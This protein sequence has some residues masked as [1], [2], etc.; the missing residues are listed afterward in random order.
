MAGL[1]L[2]IR[3]RGEAA[4]IAA[5]AGEPRRFTLKLLEEAKRYGDLPGYRIEVEGL[6]TAR[7]A[8]GA[9]PGPV[10]ALTRGA[11]VE[12]ALV[13]QMKEPT[14]I[15]WHGIELDSY[16]DGVPGW[17]GT[18]SNVTPAIAPGQEFVARFTPPRAGTF[19]YHT[20]WHDEAQLRGGVYGALIV[21]EPG[22]RF[23]P[24]T[25][26][27]FIVSMDGPSVPGQRPPYVLNGIA[28]S[29]P[30]PA[31][32]HVAVPLREGVPNRLR[33]INITPNNAALSFALTDGSKPV[34]W[35]AVAKDG[36]DLP[37]AQRISREARQLVS[38]GETYDFEIQ[39]V[40]SQRLWL[41]VRM[42]SGAWAVQALL[43]AA[44]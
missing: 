30:P 17:G 12:V 18:P 2:G 41:E 13:N 36:A 4:P 28:T 15:H 14:A 23:D 10:I 38:V 34:S 33:L 21:L 11:P 35:T 32:G 3:V 8:P 6:E 29:V 27:V 7:L 19:I 20:H 31:P 42:G 39:P 26:H 44:P 5:A 1:V 43:V 37:P 25:D 40:A 9:V 22:Q 16:F 24:A